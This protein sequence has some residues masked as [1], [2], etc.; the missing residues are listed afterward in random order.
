[1]A[2][3]IARQA[4]IAQQ[5]AMVAFVCAACVLGL[6]RSYQISGAATA[7]W[8]VAGSALQQGQATAA[9]PTAAVLGAE[10]RSLNTGRGAAAGPAGSSGEEGKP[11]LGDPRAEAVARALN[12]SAL[13]AEAGVTAATELA[14]LTQADGFKQA[15]LE[16]GPSLPSLPFPRVA[17]LF[18]TRG[19]MPFV[20]LWDEWMASAGGLVPSHA[21]SCAP[22]HGGRARGLY[23]QR[24]STCPPA[25]KSSSQGLPVFYQLSC[26]Q[27]CRIRACI[28]L[29]P[30]LGAGSRVGVRA[31]GGTA[32]AQHWG[33]YNWTQGPA[34]AA[35]SPPAPLLRVRARPRTVQ[36]AL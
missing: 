14:S 10:L 33:G 1:M 36:A 5:I 29:P 35:V 23:L 19:P 34:A 27:C 24:G 22:Q 28:P 31:G 18:L 13:A 25:L 12:H 9:P 11:M 2:A 6:L 8:Q 16:A 3:I 15:A 30:V 17:L 20:R 7:V 32:C 4:S 26:H 21:V